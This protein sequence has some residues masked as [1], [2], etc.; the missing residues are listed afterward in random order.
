MS[1]T[2]SNHSFFGLPSS[3][4][5]RNSRDIFCLWRTS[6][7][8]PPLL[9]GCS[10]CPPARANSWST[11]LWT[12][13]SPSNSY[14]PYLPL[15]CVLHAFHFAL[16]REEGSSSSIEPTINLY[17]FSMRTCLTITELIFFRSLN[18]D[19]NQPGPAYWLGMQLVN[20][21]C[22]IYFFTKVHFNLTVDWFQILQDINCNFSWNKGCFIFVVGTMS[23]DYSA[24]Y[25]I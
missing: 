5:G 22:T 2:R 23:E 11:C 8:D 4:P 14:Q 21:L 20:I 24:E 16:R 1:P 12:T 17:T 25:V 18:G 15:L 10:P 13:R 9:R 7:C 3:P 19:F 6:S